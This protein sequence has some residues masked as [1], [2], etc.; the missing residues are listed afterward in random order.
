[1]R[2]AKPAFHFSMTEAAKTGERPAPNLEWG[3]AH[4]KRASPSF[5]P[6][7]YPGLRVADRSAA[8]RASSRVIGYSN[9]TDRQ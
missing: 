6:A 7:F 1:M 5:F 9:L 4:G 2:I 3:Q 8:R